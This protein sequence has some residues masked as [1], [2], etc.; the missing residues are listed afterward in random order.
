MWNF[1]NCYLSGRHDYGMWCGSGQ[2]FLRCM[3]C[4]KRSS[5]WAVHVKT[6]TIAAEKPPTVTVAAATTSGA[7]IVPFKRAAAS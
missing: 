4:G 6:T 7:R 1:F 5:G 2:M 3:H